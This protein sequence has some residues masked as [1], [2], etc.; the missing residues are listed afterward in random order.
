MP[1]TLDRKRARLLASC[2]SCRKHDTG[3]TAL[4]IGRPPC[5]THRR[6]IAP[7]SRPPADPARASSLPLGPR[8]RSI[9]AKH[10]SGH[11]RRTNF[12]HSCLRPAPP[13]SSVNP[14]R[15]APSN[16]A[17]AGRGGAQE[18]IKLGQG[19]A[20]APL[21]ITSSTTAAMTAMINHVTFITHPQICVI[22]D[23]ALD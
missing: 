12:I 2:M 18:G 8:V 9:L 11:P 6:A 5:S 21:A 10:P 3:R 7:R 4:L 15:P 23:F 19:I 16:G 14:Q 13:P 20:F 17:G 1:K 22:F